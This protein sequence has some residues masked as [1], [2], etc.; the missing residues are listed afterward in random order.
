MT[1]DHF[2][3]AA[4]RATGM[5]A[6]RLAL[7]SAS[8]IV[9]AAGLVAVVVTHLVDFGAD[10]LR[11]RLLN[12]NSDASW[13]HL[14]V[15]ATLVAATAVAIAG[16][17]Q[18]RAGWRLC[19]GLAAILAF[20][21]ISEITTLHAEIDRMSWGKL[22]YTPLL[23]VLC[24]CA[25]GLPG[26]G[27]GRLVLRVG[28]ATLV[29]SFAIHVFGPHVV[30]ALAFNNGSWAYQIK[31]ALKQGTELAGWLLVLLG[32]WQVLLSDQRAPR[33]ASGG[34]ACASSRDRARSR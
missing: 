19:T 34:S 7:R 16:A 33:Q 9:A 5:P 1:I 12:A 32:L 17:T 3:W 14:V 26:L 22:V 15:A 28:F 6:P 23:L 10:D 13:S 21:S 18:S 11:I 20:L 8:F 29:L 30:H 31:V 4:P 2:A 24:A 25:W 27:R